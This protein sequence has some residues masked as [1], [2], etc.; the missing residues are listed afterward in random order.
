M[1]SVSV[2]VC[3]CLCK[4]Y[5]SVCVV[6]LI[7]KLSIFGMYAKWAK[8]AKCEFFLK[9]HNF[10]N[11]INTCTIS[12]LWLASVLMHTW[13]KYE[14]SK[15]NHVDRR[16]NLLK[17]L[18]FK[19]YISNWPNISCAYTRGIASYICKIWSFYDQSC[20]WEGC[21]QMPMMTMTTPHDGQSMIA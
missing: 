4:L 9:I 14:G 1:I 17:W 6:C 10:K 2:C 3:M 19:K 20:H 13:A 15:F 8:T 21:T 7:Y 16:A 11:I 18:P 12:S 5:F